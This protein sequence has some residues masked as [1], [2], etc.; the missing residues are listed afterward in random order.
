MT[1]V[2]ER[3]DSKEGKRASKRQNALTPGNAWHRL[4]ETTRPDQSKS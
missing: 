1:L 3:Q 2:D 4:D